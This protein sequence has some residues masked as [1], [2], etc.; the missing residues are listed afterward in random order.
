MKHM[1][2]IYIEG[3]TTSIKKQ[4]RYSCA[5]KKIQVIAYKNWKQFKYPTLRDSLCERAGMFLYTTWVG[6]PAPQSN[7]FLP[8]TE[9]DVSLVKQKDGVLKFE[10]MC[11]D[12][13]SLIS[14]FGEKIIMAY[15]ESID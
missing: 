13:Q 4:I 11:R 3:V 2:G 9:T 5:L 10:H 7:R 12:T 15:L 1:K 6:F 8:W 14:V